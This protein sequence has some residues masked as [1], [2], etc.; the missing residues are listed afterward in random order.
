MTD[1]LSG[2][3]EPGRCA[4][5]TMELQRGVVGD[6]AHI[7]ALAEVVAEVGVVANTARLLAGARAAGVRVVHCTAAFR[8]DTVPFRS[9]RSKYRRK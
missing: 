2:L 1:E 3:L 9:E 6:L 5:I 7:A 8:R 4:V